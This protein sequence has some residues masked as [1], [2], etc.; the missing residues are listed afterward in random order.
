[1]ILEVRSVTK[2]HFI[3]TRINNEILVFPANWIAVD[4]SLAPFDLPPG[5]YFPL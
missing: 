2:I 5:G 3:L 1:M 4:I